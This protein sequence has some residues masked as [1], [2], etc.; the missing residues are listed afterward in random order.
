[1]D[2]PPAYDVLDD[3]TLA[4]LKRNH[5]CL[6][7]KKRKVKCD[8]V[9]P[10]CNPCLRSHAHALRT[11]ARN[12]ATAGPLCCSYAEA[13]DDGSLSPHD[14]A[15]LSFGHDRRPRHPAGDKRGRRG[16]R[17]LVREK[18][19]R[20][21]EERDKLRARI[22]ELETQLAK[23]Q[24]SSSVSP[25]S[26]REMAPARATG[27]TPP[28]A[29]TWVATSRPGAQWSTT[30]T[31]NWPTS[32]TQ[33]PFQRAP[34]T[35]ATSG[36]KAPSAKG[37][38]VSDL[39]L[40]TQSD[41]NWLA[42]TL[43]GSATTI[44]DAAFDYATFA[45]TPAN[46]PRNLPVPT[47]LEHL[48]DTFY[49]CVPQIPRILH[50][51][52]LM[53]RLNYPPLHAQFPLPALLH[54]IC[55]AAAPHTA[56]VYSVAPE[57]VEEVHIRHVKRGLD[58]ELIE[59]F[60]TAQVEAALR[61]IRQNVASCAV[62]PGHELFDLL[63]AHLIL[64][65]VDMSMSR[66]LRAWL[67]G[68]VP[69][70][71][72]KTLGLEN[73]N[74][75]RSEKPALLKEPAGDGEREERIAAVWMAYMQDVALSAT[76]AWSPTM[77]S[78]DIK[79]PL[80]TSAEQ[81][82]RNYYVHGN[83]QLNPQGVDSPDLL[84]RHPIP[85]PFVLAV[86]A[87]ILVGKVSHWIQDWQQRVKTP[88][89]DCD[90]VQTSSFINLNNTIF[91]F[92]LGLPSAIKNVY[93]QLDAG[94]T[95]VF[96]P[97]VVMVHV[98]PHVGLMLLHDL[99]VDWQG[100]E[101]ASLNQLQ[102]AYEAV[103]A[104]VHLIPPQVDI[105]HVMTPAMCMSF[106]TVGRIIAK[107]AAR[108]IVSQNFEASLKHRSD[109]STVQGLMMRY[110]AKHAFGLNMA[111]YLDHYYDL[112]LAAAAENR[113]PA[114]V[115]EVCMDVAKIRQ[116]SAAATAAVASASVTPPSDYGSY[117]SRS[118]SMSAP[119]GG[120]SSNP[121]FTPPNAVPDAGP[122]TASAPASAA[123]APSTFA[124][125]DPDAPFD[126]SF[127]AN[128]G[129]DQLGMLGS[130]IMA[131]GTTLDALLGFGAGDFAGL[132]GQGGQEP[133]AALKQPYGQPVGGG[134]MLG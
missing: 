85:D 131:S 66:P 110:G 89:D 27:V 92:Q 117:A 18:E 67:T 42:S 47:L 91:A 71:L 111:T 103:L 61:S 38:F 108:A 60:Q 19:R 104:F 120:G 63:R 126:A 43:V 57:K 94:I 128:I 11:A 99:F 81:F 87:C 41:S 72:I 122:S 2:L 4:P 32:G 132:G 50:R 31:A 93:K 64:C 119:S 102:R 124:N 74:A 48:I 79:H 101:N 10:T 96:D 22:A 86:K 40:L 114:D 69:N 68:G 75:V 36:L 7:C 30:A 88:G 80:P 6:Q 1:M 77:N 16:E 106:Y 125:Y 73:R 51:G 105:A 95:T 8:G 129:L 116:H 39:E 76:V 26:E 59:D 33:N 35:W 46:W 44:D 83:M 109:L 9:R 34:T 21:E 5:A 130:D 100:P 49:K 123:A 134:P 121:A 45:L 133:F 70:R 13:D 25:T 112:V 127:F 17:N 56:A 90:G 24:P 65:E 98:L 107:F 115:R 12:K 78:A 23:L 20:Q 118:D 82:K 29:S 84:Y 14:E 97:N 54:A 62:G 15:E 3:E 28:A 52:N 113:G 37:P 58:L 53:A 55:A